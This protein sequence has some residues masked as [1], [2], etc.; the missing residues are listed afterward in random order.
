VSAVL[1]LSLAGVAWK[2][3]L[4]TPRP[5]RP[6]QPPISLESVDPRLAYAGPL[7]NVRPE[8]QYLGDAR[9]AECH[10]DIA[11]SY[12]HH[13]MGRSLAPVAELA[14]SQAYDEKHHNPFTA[15]DS[16]FV[17]ERQ[18]DRV[19]HR[20]TRLDAAGRPV[21]ESA[22]EVGYA[23]GA[24]RSGFSYIT[25]RNGYLF[26]TPISWYSQKD[27]WDVSPGFSAD[28]LTGRPVTGDCL[29]CHTNRAHAV[30]GYQNRYEQPVFSGHAIGCERCHGPGGLHARSLKAEDIVN[31]GKLDPD[32]REAVCQ[33]CHLEGETRV[34]R[35]GRGLY[36]FRP[37]LPLSDFWSVF[38]RA[39]VGREDQRAV[40]H[41]EQMYAS[42][43]FQ[44]SRDD[45]K[46][47]CTS[48]HDPHVSVAPERRVAYFRDRCLRCHEAHAAATS[49]AL[50]AEERQRQSPSD[51]CVDCHMPRYT[52]TDVAHSAATDHRIPRRPMKPDM[53]ELP[54]PAGSGLLL[55]PFGQ[56]RLDLRDHELVR[57][58]GIAL[59]KA[60]MAGRLPR[61][62]AASQALGLLETSLRRFPD[63]VEGHEARGW[64]LA[65]DEQA[66]QALAAF[67]AA[68]AR[69]PRREMSLVG[70]ALMTEATGQHLR[71]L[72]Y[73]R[74]C[75]EM[76]P[77]LAL[78][79]RHLA[80]ALARQ[81]AW[82]ELRP[83]VQAWLRLD[84]GSAEGRMLWV[85]CLLHDGRKA[86]AAAE[87]G[88][89]EALRPPELEQL[90]ATYQR[91]SHDH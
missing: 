53:P 1:L 74:R 7:R 31:P 28:L 2:A 6:D 46:L 26:Q 63:D 60:S 22:Q 13:R 64:A 12:R 59:L 37:G 70:A 91:L 29:F 19:W 69:E 40:H 34:L 80:Q 82:D 21:Y 33:Q 68:L 38:V 52:L 30:E 20:Q 89:I 8:V 25:D 51:S 5:P 42:K 39:H 15:L 27:R 88:R 3:G 56:Q 58:A 79:R 35:R 54:E 17:V 44:S 57:D 86:D 41:V 11:E 47:G 16:R 77:E 62:A 67:E 48:C 23:V 36:D 43:C 32:L 72:D 71:A 24:G 85:T 18:G 76:N 78:Y 87:F 4:L 9:C 50:P 14:V 66:P 75:V 65:T 73:W 83:Q 81:Q 55:A 90:R 61:A 45:A 84:P 49:C 10:A